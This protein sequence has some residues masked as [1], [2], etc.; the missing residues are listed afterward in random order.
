MTTGIL[1]RGVSVCWR[2][3]SSAKD[4]HANWSL[5][6]GSLSSIICKETMWATKMKMV[7]FSFGSY[8]QCGIWTHSLIH[9]RQV[10]YHWVIDTPKPPKD[11]ISGAVI[12][13]HMIWWVYCLSSVNMTKKKKVEPPLPLSTHWTLSNNGSQHF[14]VA[15]IH[16]RVLVQGKQAETSEFFQD[17]PA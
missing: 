8:T 14:T 2:D 15:V 4:T 17:V 9:A 5:S 10:L 7:C 11:I 6:I 12:R 16:F 1:K 3:R 13:L